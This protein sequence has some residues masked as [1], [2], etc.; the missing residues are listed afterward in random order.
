MCKI[1]SISCQNNIVIQILTYI[2]HVSFVV[3]KW[4]DHWSIRFISNG[5]KKTN[6]KKL[7]GRIISF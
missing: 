6:K 1:K 4:R 5:D 7:I 2:L 3:F